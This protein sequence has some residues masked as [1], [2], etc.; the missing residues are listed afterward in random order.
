MA[1][2]TC[3]VHRGTNSRA[4]VLM[5]SA[6]HR[7]SYR[8]WWP[9]DVHLVPLNRALDSCLCTCV[10][11]HESQAKRCQNHFHQPQFAP[12]THVP[13][14]FTLAA[15]T[16]CWSSVYA[17][18]IPALDGKFLKEESCA[19][20]RI[21]AGPSQGK[22]CQNVSCWEGLWPRGGQRE[23]PRYQTSSP[24]QDCC[25]SRSREARDS[26]RATLQ[27]MTLAWE[28]QWLK[29][30]LW[31]GACRLVGQGLHHTSFTCT[32]HPSSQHQRIFSLFLFF[33]F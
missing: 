2:Y 1:G 16:P 9:S 5:S 26:A 21:T 15:L 13:P 29:C 33:S 8:G 20:Q 30:M 4:C 18:S 27:A 28:E 17:G 12:L 19:F 3:G 32:I 11:A 25:F 24:F 7:A 6:L 22:H 14:A 10:Q 31:V 23:Y